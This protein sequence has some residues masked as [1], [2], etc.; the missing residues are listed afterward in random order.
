MVLKFCGEIVAG[1]SGWVPGDRVIGGPVMPSGAFA[2][3][4]VM[5][6]AHIMPAPEVLDDCG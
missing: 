1:G 4:A 2:E 5:D 6:A 3:F